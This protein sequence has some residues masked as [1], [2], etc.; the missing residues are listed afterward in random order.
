MKDNTSFIS[1][2]ITFMS[3]RL[4][5]LDLIFPFATTLQQRCFVPFSLALVGRGR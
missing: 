4:S 3:L 1:S 2:I 5:L